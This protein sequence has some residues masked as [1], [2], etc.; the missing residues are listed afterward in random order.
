[1]TATDA[2]ATMEELLEVVFSM[3]SLPRNSCDYE[4][5]ETAVRR[6]MAANAVSQLGQRVSRETVA[7]QQGLEHGS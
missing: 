3:R 6:A 4:S 1:M 7:G 5:L 2:H